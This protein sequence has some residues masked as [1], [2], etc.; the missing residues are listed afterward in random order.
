MAFRFENLAD[1]NMVRYIMSVGVRIDGEL[2]ES[3][4]PQPRLHPYPSVHL[5]SVIGGLTLITKNH[6][7]IFVNDPQSI[8]P[9]AEAFA[10]YSIEY[11]VNAWTACAART[12][13]WKKSNQATGGILAI[14]LPRRWMQKENI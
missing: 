9:G 12:I 13:S 10:A 2:K 4:R 3:Q 8:D 11:L 1:A 5:W 14:G 7:C 6:E